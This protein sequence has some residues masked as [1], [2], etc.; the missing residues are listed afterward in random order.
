MLTCEN[1]DIEFNGRTFHVQTEDWG[2]DN[3]YLVTRVFSGGKVLGSIKTNYQSWLS[4]SEE[5][6]AQKLKKVLSYQHLES[7]EKIKQGHWY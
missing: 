2:L 3:P 4:L 7:I 5:Q 1:T 6:R